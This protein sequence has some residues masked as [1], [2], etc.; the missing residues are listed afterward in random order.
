MTRILVVED[1]E[2]SRENLL[3]LLEA[4]GFETCGA[5]DGRA[6]VEQAREHL[7]D[8]IVCDI[9]MPELDG[10]GVLAELRGDPVTASIPFIFLTAKTDRSDMRQ[11]M[12]LGADD[13]LTKPFRRDDV[14]KAISTRLDKQATVTKKFQKKL[15][16]LRGSIALSL[17]HELRTPLTGIMGYSSIL[18]EDYAA[19]SPKEIGDMAQSIYRSAE[20]LNRLVLNFVLYTELQVATQDPE[21]AEA[22]L[23]NGRCPAASTIT[24]AAHR[25]AHQMERAS[26]L[27]ATV[28]EATAKIDG[29]F[30]EK[31]VQELL[32]NAFK[33]SPAGTPVHVVGKRDERE[34][35][36]S[37]SNQGRGMTP[38]Q[39]ADLGAFK[40]FDRTRHEQQGQGLGLTIA[41]RLVELHGGRLTVESVPEQSLTV[42]ITLPLYSRPA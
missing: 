22:L 9:A 12:E 21:Y 24:D 5:A 30:L 19:M 8:L 38:D 36:L 40:Q 29:K 15:D 35:T 18:A 37:I 2:A 13:Y 41:K 11:G 16:D 28:D 27:L 14:L 31:I 1:D 3:F 6:G 4:E 33:F 39:I 32:S 23:G 26:D 25:L 10:Y 20:R 34:F 7:P 17:P 42:R